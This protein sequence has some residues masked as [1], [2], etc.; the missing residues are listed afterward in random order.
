MGEKRFARPRCNSCGN[1]IYQT[2]N[3]F[4]NYYWGKIPNNCPNCG[5]E[6]SNAKK[7]QLLHYDELIWSILCVIFITFAIIVMII[8][9]R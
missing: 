1:P 6:L 5:K 3:P 9:S 2:H 7:K 8:F 4:K